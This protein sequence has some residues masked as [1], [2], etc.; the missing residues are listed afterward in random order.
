VGRTNLRGHGVWTWRW[1]RETRHAHDRRARS[2]DSTCEH[3]IR[4]SKSRPTGLAEPSASAT[5]QPSPTSMASPSGRNYCE[6][7]Q[8]P[9]I[10]PP[11]ETKT[12]YRRL[13]LSHHPDNSDLTKDRPARADVDIGF[14]LGIHHPI[15][16]AIPNKARCRTLLPPYLSPSRNRP[17][18]GLSLEDFED[19]G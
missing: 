7:L 18:H 6:L 3:G 11:A 12:S 17:A 14:S 19:L 13:L 5:S 15:F 8:I 10:A 9:L 16:P 1:S 2:P 4:M